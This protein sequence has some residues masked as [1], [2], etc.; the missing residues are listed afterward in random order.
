MKGHRRVLDASDNLLKL[1][2][3]VV[4]TDKEKRF[5]ERTEITRRNLLEDEAGLDEYVR[6]QAAKRR[7]KNKLQP[8]T[9]Q[10][11]KQKAASIIRLQKSKKEGPKK[12][13]TIGDMV[14]TVFK[15]N[16]IDK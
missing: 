5:A 16:G 4:L 9:E 15:K 6:E 10:K 13:L 12:Q 7:R 14:T 2:A 11:D 3:E 1:K 8:S